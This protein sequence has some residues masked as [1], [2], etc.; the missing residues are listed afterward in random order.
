MAV[1]SLKVSYLCRTQNYQGM[2][3]ML[4]YIDG[5]LIGWTN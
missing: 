2:D 3:T 4:V 1:F 5:R